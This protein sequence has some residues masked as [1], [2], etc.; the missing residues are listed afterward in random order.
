LQIDRALRIDSGWTID[1]RSNGSVRSGAFFSAN[2]PHWE[3]FSGGKVGP[4]RAALQSCA[5]VHGFPKAT[6]FAHKAD[7]PIFWTVPVFQAD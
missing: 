4:I 1:A 7:L 5:T 2:Q 3:R 6:H